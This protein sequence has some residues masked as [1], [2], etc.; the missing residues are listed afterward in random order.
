MIPVVDSFKQ[1]GKIIANKSPEAAAMAKAG[2]GEAMNLKVQSRTARKLLRKSFA[3][4][5]GQEPNQKRHCFRL[6]PPG[7]CLSKAQ[8]R[9]TWQPAQRFTSALSLRPAMKQKLL[10]Q[11]SRGFKLLKE[12]ESFQYGRRSPRLFPL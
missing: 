6:P 1:F 12:K 7:T 8:T 9:Q 4:R 5:L 10:F 2:L 3:R 11:A